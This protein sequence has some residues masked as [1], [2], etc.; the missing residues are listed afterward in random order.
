MKTPSFDAL[1]R[2]LDADDMHRLLA[3][4]PTSAARP[5]RSRAASRRP[6]FRRGLLLRH[7]RLALG[8]D[9]LKTLWTRPRRCPASSTATTACPRS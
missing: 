4:F 3:G 9:I 1:R 2:R 6:P 7:G 5:G 8:G